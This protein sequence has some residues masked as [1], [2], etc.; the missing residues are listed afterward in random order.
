MTAPAAIMC[1]PRCQGSGTVQAAR[2]KVTVTEAL[3][4]DVIPAAVSTIY[5]NS[6]SGRWPWVTRVGPG[7]RRDRNLWIDIGPAVEW[8]VA[9]GRPSVAARLELL[10]REGGVR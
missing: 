5:E 1:C 6:K 9:D 10:A 8:W 2:T 7:G 4:A 3:R